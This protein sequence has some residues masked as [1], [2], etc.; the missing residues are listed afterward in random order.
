M[1]KVLIIFIS[2]FLFHHINSQTIISGIYD[3][4]K[5]LY[6]TNDKTLWIDFFQD[7]IARISKDGF[8]GLMNTKGKILCPPKYDM[9][10]DFENDVA[11]V[12][13][14]GKFGLINKNGKELII[15][16]FENIEK[17]NQNLYIINQKENKNEYGILKSDGSF[18]TNIK[19]PKLQ[20][21]K[22]KTIIYDDGKNI[23][24]IDLNTG[25]EMP[26][27]EY[28][29]G[30]YARIIGALEY[31]N[32]LTITYKKTDNSVLYGFMDEN[33]KT[34]IEPQYDWV[35]PF[36]NGYASVEKDNKWGVID[37]FGTSI[38]P[39]DFESVQILENHKF[40]VRKNGKLGVLNSDN[41]ILI[42]LIYNSQNK[43]K[44]IGKPEQSIL[45]P[46]FKSVK[47]LED[48]KFS[49]QETKKFGVSDINI[50]VS[51]WGKIPRL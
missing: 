6:I 5:N 46:S 18:L 33:F 30:G 38:L 4:D 31:N 20:V 43:Q 10:Y 11:K 42:P 45:S 25:K 51:I 36:E 16:Q 27:F 19:Y 12:G 26:V 32:G 3:G 2:L 28:E 41:Q 22:D 14:N 17:V 34:V 37:T 21:T 24:L 35:K 39:P 44:A 8:M 23:G 7:G 1:R 29:N 47:M 50:N 40:L 48:D 49:Y 15:P 13:L 9:I